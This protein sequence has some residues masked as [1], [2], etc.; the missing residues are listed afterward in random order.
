MFLTRKAVRKWPRS[1]AIEAFRRDGRT[2]VRKVFP[3]TLWLAEF[4]RMRAARAV[5]H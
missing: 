1:G 4:E 3:N 5:A 2:K